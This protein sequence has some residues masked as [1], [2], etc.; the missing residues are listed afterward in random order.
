[1]H[2]GALFTDRNLFYSTAVYTAVK[3]SGTFDF[4]LYWQFI[5]S[6]LGITMIYRKKFETPYIHST[7]KLLQ[8][9]IIFF[10]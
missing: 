3:K 8:Y 4:D 9:D 5:S 1:M 2:S 6:A 7:I 10:K